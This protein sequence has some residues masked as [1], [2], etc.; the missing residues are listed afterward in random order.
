MLSNKNRVLYVCWVIFCV[1]INTYG[2]VAEPKAANNVFTF[3]IEACLELNG[4]IEVK[5]NVSLKC[6][7]FVHLFQ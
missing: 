4:G 7:Q 3:K 1:K 6:E 5:Y 2:L